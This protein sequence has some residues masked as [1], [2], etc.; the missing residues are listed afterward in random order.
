MG[1]N[2][3]LLTVFCEKI[4]LLHCSEPSLKQAKCVVLFLRNRQY[5]SVPQSIVR[6]LKVVQLS[7]DHVDLSLIYCYHRLSF[8]GLN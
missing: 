7:N 6:V 4:E 3:W 2:L 5:A 8:T 1:F